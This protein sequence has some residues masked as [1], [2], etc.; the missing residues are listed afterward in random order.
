MNK[1]IPISKSRASKINVLIF[2]FILLVAGVVIF[3]PKKSGVITDL[4]T[5]LSL[6]TCPANL[7]GLVTYPIMDKGVIRGLIPLGN[8]NPPGHTF[9]VDHIYFHGEPDGVERNV[10]AAGDGVIS[11]VTMI[12]TYGLDGKLKSMGLTL[13]IDYCKGIQL[14]NAIEGEPSAIITNVIG[15]QQESCKL[16]AA[17]H[18]GESGIDFCGYSV[19]IPVKAADIVAITD[20][21]TFPEIWALDKNKPL[22]KDV[23][24]ERYNSPYYQYA[25]CFFDM[26]PQDLKDYYYSLFGN[27]VDTTQAFLKDIGNGKKIEVKSGL[28]P[29]TIP[30]L[31]GNVM[32]NVVG[33]AK[34]DWFGE[35]RDDDSE[36]SYEKDLA[37]IED[38]QDPTYQRVVIAGYV[39]EPSLLNFRVVHSG[40]IN[41]DFAEVTADGKT[42]CYYLTNDTGNAGGWWNGGKIVLRLVDAHNLLIEKQEGS[43]TGQ[44]QLR[45]P[46]KYDR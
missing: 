12:K 37:L 15:A 5:T 30:P 8:S 39:S 36:T 7:Q 23:D 41:R 14:V 24:W 35:G 19:S 10:Y 11:N 1:Q 29:R 2:F 43:C 44:E 16:V 4:K 13:T 34:G 21:K 20:G 25:F 31:C 28:I 32:Q 9:P 42:Y 26:Y 33:T 3:L 6:P 22:S 27:Y 46:K 18:E 45:S 40:T 17:K 38:N